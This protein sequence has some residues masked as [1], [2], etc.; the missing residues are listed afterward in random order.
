MVFFANVARARRRAIV[1]EEN[2]FDQVDR[3]HDRI[4]AQRVTPS[5]TR[6]NRVNIGRS[7]RE[8]RKAAEQ[9]YKRSF[10]EDNLI[11]E[12]EA[13]S[14]LQSALGREERY[15]QFKKESMDRKLKPVKATLGFFKSVGQGIK[16]RK[17]RAGIFKGFGQQSKGFE[18]MDYTNSPFRK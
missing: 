10:A 12:K 3:E 14:K 8:K 9:E 17:A 16:K 18:G 2:V 6:E 7:L 11:K 1:K 5:L 4:S 15:K 13:H